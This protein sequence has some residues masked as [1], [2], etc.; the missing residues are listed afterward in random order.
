MNAKKMSFQIK[1]KDKKKP[2]TSGFKQKQF[3][4]ESFRSSSVSRT[5]E[6]L[7]SQGNKKTSE[8]FIQR[9]NELGKK[10]QVNNC[11]NTCCLCKDKAT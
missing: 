10:N 7:L 5:G 6:A 2:E 3:T 11:E 8:A 9:Y 1:K 4:L